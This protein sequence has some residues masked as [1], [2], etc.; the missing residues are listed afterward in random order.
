M[1]KDRGLKPLEA[2]WAQDENLP[3]GVRL[4]THL[5]MVHWAASAM[6]AAEGWYEQ[7]S[8]GG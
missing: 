6:D 2:R 3:E 8:A 5:G 1:L 7:G 4:N